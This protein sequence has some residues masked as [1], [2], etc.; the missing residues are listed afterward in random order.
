MFSL[1][2]LTSAYLCIHIAFSANAL[3]AS[4]ALSALKQP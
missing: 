4:V 2:V 3:I 1:V